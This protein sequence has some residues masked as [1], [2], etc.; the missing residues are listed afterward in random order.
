MNMCDITL[1][2]LKFSTFVFTSVQKKKYSRLYLLLG[3]FG[4]G[5]NNGGPVSQ[6]VAQHYLT[7]GPMY[8]VIWVVVF[9]AAGDQSVTRIGIAPN[10]LHCMQGFPQSI[11]AS[12]YHDALNFYP[13]ASV[14]TMMLFQ[15]P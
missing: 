2:V 8:R 12:W 11:K 14:I 13:D 9:L 4:F 1:Q 3:A 10:N 5:W 15:M 6:T 7:I